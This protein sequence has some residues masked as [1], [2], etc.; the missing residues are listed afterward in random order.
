[1]KKRQLFGKLHDRIHELD[2]R[3]GNAQNLRSEVEN[4]SLINY[5]N[6]DQILELKNEIL[7]LKQEIS[8]LKSLVSN[9]ESKIEKLENNNQLYE[10]EL[11]YMEDRFSNLKEGKLILDLEKKY[12]KI[13]QMLE[14]GRINRNLINTVY[15]NQV[16]I[17]KNRR[18]RTELRSILIMG[19]A[20]YICSKLGC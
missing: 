11:C 17:L 16:K 15:E 6:E 20:I 18:K 10:E 8:D 19:R 3:V 12:E 7:N 13:S 9:Y 14:K 1:M 4:L 5:K 2:S